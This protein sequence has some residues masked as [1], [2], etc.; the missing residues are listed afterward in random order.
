M[1]LRRVAIELELVSWISINY[2]IRAW[3]GQKQV[4][5]LEVHSGDPDGKWLRMWTR[6]RT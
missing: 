1:F 5:Q 4:D 2:V 3:P 6:V